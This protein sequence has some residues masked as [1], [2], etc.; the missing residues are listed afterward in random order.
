MGGS[1]RGLSAKRCLADLGQVGV[2]HAPWLAWVLQVGR[3]TGGSLGRGDFR[4]SGV[5]DA[6]VSFVDCSRLSWAITRSDR[7]GDG[8]KV[9]RCLSKKSGG[10]LR[11]V[12]YVSA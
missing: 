6:V 3:H 12:S 7:V 2:P 8:W 11:S 5:C 4:R 10:R 9:L 1:V